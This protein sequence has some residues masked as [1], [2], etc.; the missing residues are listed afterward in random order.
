LAVYLGIAFIAIYTTAIIGVAI[1]SIVKCNGLAQISSRFCRNYAK[2]VV[3]MN[4]VINVVTD[5]YVLVLPIPCI[6][7]LQLSLK[8][9]IGLLLA[10][11]SGIV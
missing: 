5:F 6:M 11:G 9:R 3:V 2:P 7:K 10:F 1:G 4:S 8:R